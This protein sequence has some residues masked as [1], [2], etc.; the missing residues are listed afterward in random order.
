MSRWN[1]TYEL[2]RESQQSP[3]GDSGMQISRTSGGGETAPA[4]ERTHEPNAERQPPSIVARPIERQDL[5]LHDLSHLITAQRP[6]LLTHNEKA[7]HLTGAQVRAL[8]TI[9]AFRAIPRDDLV[10]RQLLSRDELAELRGQGLISQH[11]VSLQGEMRSIVTL[12][13]EAKHVLAAHRSAP[14]EAE[15]HA[16]QPL[17]SGL[18]KRG[19]LPHDSHLY[20]LYEVAAADLVSQGAAI[21]RV[22]LDYTLKRDYQQFLNRRDRDP[23]SSLDDDRRAWAEAHGLTVVD[24]ELHFPDLRIEYIDADGEQRTHD[25]ELVTVHYSARSIAAK[26][27]A[28]FTL[29]RKGFTPH[30]NLFERLT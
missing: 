12:T 3:N 16:Q 9:G 17:H 7:Y 21:E 20:A 11:S 23:D 14:L 29:Y 26:R 19:E 10:D 2:Y 13:T 5:P 8:G 4:Q 15:D 1:R 30:P 28:G 27:G 24:G 18:V 25:V 6:Q 22:Q